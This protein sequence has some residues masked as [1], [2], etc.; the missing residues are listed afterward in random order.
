[1][2]KRNQTQKPRS[3]SSL[4]AF[5]AF[6][7]ARGSLPLDPEEERE[8]F[9]LDLAASRQCSSLGLKAPELGRGSR[10]PGMKLNYERESSFKYHGA[11]FGDPQIPEG[12]IAHYGICMYPEEDWLLWLQ[13]AVAMADPEPGTGS[14]KKRVDRLADIQRLIKVVRRKIQEAVD[15]ADETW[16][17]FGEPDVLPRCRQVDVGMECGLPDYTTSRCFSDEGADALNAL[18][19]KLADR[20]FILDAAEHRRNARR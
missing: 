8:L 7:E 20:E 1:M 3:P 5:C 16:A 19:D 17:K 4:E 18:W 14:A 10:T 6:V 12:E 15:H 11:L 2:A 13:A 9:A